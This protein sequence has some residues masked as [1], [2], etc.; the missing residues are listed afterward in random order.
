MELTHDMINPNGALLIL[1][2]SAQGELH[3]GYLFS[4]PAYA[5][6]QLGSGPLVEAIESALMAGAPIVQAIRIADVSASIPEL[7]TELSE[8][9]LDFSF[10]EAGQVLLAGVPACFTEGS[11]IYDFAEQL[12]EA[13][14]SHFSYTPMVGILP[15]IVEDGPPPGDLHEHVT[16]L[17]NYAQAVN[18]SALTRSTICMVASPVYGDYRVAYAFA[19]S[20]AALPLGES[21][22]H[23]S[24]LGLSDHYDWP[25]RS[26]YDI[27]GI[28]YLDALSAYGYTAISRTA[29][30]GVAAYNAVIFGRR[31]GLRSTRIMHELIRKLREA[32]DLVLGRPSQPQIRSGFEAA[33]NDIFAE[34]ATVGAIDP[35]YTI[36]FAYQFDEILVSISAKV[37]DD[38]FKI[39]LPMRIR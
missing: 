33:V 19:G 30:R 21:P 4:S 18:T 38:V 39:T 11:F 35:E 5:Q 1:G 29:R 16:R 13:L 23:A 22:T 34:S 15:A 12:A 25:Y 17:F 7:Y 31:T 26:S 2:P 32:S 6:E 3:E 14:D 28:S 9:Y 37:Y 8:I 24:I 10:Q 27:N 20:L 36:G